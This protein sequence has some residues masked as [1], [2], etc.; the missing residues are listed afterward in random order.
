MKSL[1]RGGKKAPKFK[2]GESEDTFAWIFSSQSDLA[3]HLWVLKNKPQLLP[4][5]NHQL[6]WPPDASPSI[7]KWQ[8][9]F[10]GQLNETEMHGGFS[11]LSYGQQGK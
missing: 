9:S 4:R 2:Q 6:Q 7:N 5:T 8:K 1:N 11:P 10:M 3:Y